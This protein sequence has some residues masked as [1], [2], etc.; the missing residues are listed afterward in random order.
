MPAT[1]LPAAPPAPRPWWFRLAGWALTLALTAVLAW[2]V[3]DRGSYGATQ[4]TVADRAASPLTGEPA[5]AITAQS[6]HPNGS[7]L[8]GSVIASI[9][10]HGVVAHEVGSGRELWRYVRSDTTV[11]ARHVDAQRVTL[12]YASGARCDE[13]VSLK[14]ADGTRQWQ[15]TIEAVHPN[16]IIWAD[17]SFISVDPAKTIYFDSTQGF[18]RFTLDNS[19]TDHVA[20]EHTSCE[21]L[22]AAGA[23]MVATLQRCRATEDAPWI[24]QVVVNEAS[25][26][27]PREAGRSYLS[28]VRDPAIEG[29][30]PDG[31]TIL[32]DGDG[33]VLSLPLNAAEPTPVAGIPPIAPSEPLDVIAVRG[34]VLLSTDETAYSL[35]PARTAVSWS[36]GIV[37]SPYPLGTRI[38][39]P[40]AAGIEERAALDGQLVRTIGWAPLVAGPAELVVSGPLVGVRDT[41]G[42]RIYA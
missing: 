9:T 17:G 13:A 37:A 2:V 42:L 6:T 3:V 23:P 39:L 21:N 19:T 35:N 27:D 26:G 16:R 38:Y 33:V 32:R 30:S 40:T 31:T 29:V 1:P 24:Y 34:T 14:P 41:T 12:I 8:A 28:A 36:R 25:D 22:D 15:R 11:C 5:A 18:E 7:Y 10:E 20:G 4:H